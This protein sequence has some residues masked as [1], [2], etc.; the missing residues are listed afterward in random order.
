MRQVKPSPFPQ[1]SKYIFN[2]SEKN[3]T[4]TL[5]MTCQQVLGSSILGQMSLELTKVQN[6][7]PLSINTT[8]NGKREKLNF[9]ST[10]LP[11]DV[12]LGGRKPNDPQKQPQ[13][14]RL[15]QAEQVEIGR[16]ST[17]FIYQLVLAPHF[18]KRKQ[19]FLILPNNPEASSCPSIISG[20]FHHSS[21]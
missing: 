2:H 21:P 18:N 19:N 4:L 14:V 12:T 1:F 11:V 10:L 8:F 3:S 17:L 13:L 20:K 9:T 15:T 7:E 6:V 16:I 5:Q